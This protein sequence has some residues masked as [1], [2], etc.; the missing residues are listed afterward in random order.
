VRQVGYLQGQ[1][2]VIY[3]QALYLP[4]KVWHTRSTMATPVLH[5]TRTTCSTAVRTT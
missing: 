3:L 4:L 1:E 2:S 5:A